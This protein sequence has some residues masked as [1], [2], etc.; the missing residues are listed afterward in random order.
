M[1]DHSLA[2][3]IVEVFLDLWAQGNGAFPGGVYNGMDIMLELDLVFA[4]ESTNVCDSIWELLYQVISGPDGLGCCRD[5]RP[6]MAGPGVSGMYQYEFT[7]WGQA[8][9]WPSHQVMGP[10]SAPYRGIWDP[11]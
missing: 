10:Q 1:G 8:P 11:L 6:R 2:A 7:L 5:C 4:R 9:G 3:H